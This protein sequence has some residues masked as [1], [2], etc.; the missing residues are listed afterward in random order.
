MIVKAKCTAPA[1]DSPSAVYYAPG[2][3]PLEGGLYEIDTEGPL[4]ALKIGNRYVFDFDR[5]ANPEDKPHDYTC[6]ECGKDLKTLPALGSHKRKEHAK[7]PAVDNEPVVVAKHGLK[8]RTATMKC[9]DCGEKFP[10]LHALK[11]H[12]K[13]DHAKVEAEPVLA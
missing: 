3:G 4:P 7:S 11:V 1:W 9:R 6:D 10:N 13:K 5:N 2:G 8:G 12:K